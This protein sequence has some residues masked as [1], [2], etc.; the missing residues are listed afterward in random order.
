M[1]V[2]TGTV[3]VPGVKA[4][5]LIVTATSAAF[6]GAGEPTMNTAA[7]APARSSAN[8]VRNHRP[9]PPPEYRMGSPS[10]YAVRI[11]TASAPVPFS[12]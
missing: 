10:H 4:K 9:L 1:R 11:D 3:I 6:T 8:P 2:P 7:Q 12:V 5:L